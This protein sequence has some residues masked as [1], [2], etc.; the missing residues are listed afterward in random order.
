MNKESVAIGDDNFEFNIAAWRERCL[1]LAVE[2]EQWAKTNN[3]GFVLTS[4]PLNEG[5]VKLMR[6]VCSDIN[7]DSLQHLFEAKDSDA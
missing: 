5:I 3:M 1:E 2:A 6:V 4:C 7:N